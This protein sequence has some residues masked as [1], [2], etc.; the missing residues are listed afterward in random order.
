M[1]DEKTD[2]KGSWQLREPHSSGPG[3]QAGL[4]PASTS[5]Q[6]PLPQYGE[7]L[8]GGGGRPSWQFNKGIIDAICDIVPAVKPQC[9]FYEA[10]RLAGHAGAG[11]DDCLCRRQRECIVIIDGKRNDIG[12][13]MTGLRQPPIWAQVEV[14]GEAVSRPLAADALTVNGYLGSDGIQPL[15]DDVRRGATRGSSCWSRPPTPPPASCRTS[16]W[17][18]A[19]TVYGADGRPCARG[20]AESCPDSYGYSGVG[21]VVGATYPAQLAELRAAGCPTPSSWCPATARRAAAP[22]MSIGRA[23]TSGAS[24]PSSTPPAR[25]SPPGR[26]RRVPASA[27]SPRPPGREALRMQEDLR[28]SD[29]G[30]PEDIRRTHRVD[31]RQG[32]P[33]E[34][35]WYGGVMRRKC[36]ESA[37]C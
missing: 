14:D 30:H 5:R 22:R 18:R 37:A 10:V 25:C 23:L 36:A 31:I 33:P 11:R 28:R 8:E 17:R 19:S 21:A 20:G 24:A 16:C 9:A 15:L 6:R 3:P 29:H 32:R 13:T 34:S 27:T 7:T 35:Q 26:S 1:S 4:H 12:S 2:P